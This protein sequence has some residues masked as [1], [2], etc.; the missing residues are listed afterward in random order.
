M[1]HSRQRKKDYKEQHPNKKVKEK[2]KKMLYW[3]T[4]LAGLVAVGL[5]IY[6]ILKLLI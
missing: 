6:G 3:I 5:L 4:L 2:Y 1:Q